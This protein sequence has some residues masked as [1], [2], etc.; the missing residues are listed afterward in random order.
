MPM[1][2]VGKKYVCTSTTVK[3]SIKKTHNMLVGHETPR[4][5]N[6]PQ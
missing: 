1:P 3:N 6:Y 2:E 5:H 4:K